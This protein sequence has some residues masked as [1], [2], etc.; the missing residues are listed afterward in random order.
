M[1]APQLHEILAVEG[2]QQSRAQLLL[3]QTTS[4]FKNKEILFTGKTRRL[5]M[6][7]KDEAN[8][9]EM[10]ALEAKEARNSPVA[11]TIP[12]NL[13]Y[14]ASL[15]AQYYN[16]VY[17]KEA[18]NQ[19]AKADIVVNGLTLLK[20]VPVTFLLCM[21]T[22]L[23]ALRQVI[24]EAPSLDPAVIWTL[25]KTYAMPHVYK[26]PE[27]NDTKTSKEIDHKVIVPPSDKHPAQVAAQEVSRNIGRYTDITWSGKIS[28]AD[29]ASLLG[30]LDG[31]IQGVKKARQRAN[32]TSVIPSN[33]AGAVLMKYVLGDWFDPSSANP[34]AT[35]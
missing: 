8:K 29:K 7:A 19:I 4:T 21:E 27:V 34:E 5:I 24:I 31:L 3:S 10:D 12:G 25:D 15:L 13:N 33:D 11:A 30:R 20:D 18:T 26:A 6:F 22:R 14:L 35:V 16:V 17:E 23:Q 28:S 1:S 9:V 32:S 2:D